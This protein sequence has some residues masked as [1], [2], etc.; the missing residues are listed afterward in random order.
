MMTYRVY[1][2]DR[3]NHIKSVEVVPADNDAAAL[4]IAQQRHVNG[5]DVELWHDTRIVVRLPRNEKPR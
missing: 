4:D 5:Y 2:I 1:L 3:E